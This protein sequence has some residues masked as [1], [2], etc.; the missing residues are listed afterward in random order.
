MERNGWES[1]GLEG[2]GS[3]LTRVVKERIGGDWTGLEVIGW[4]GMG[5]ERM[6]SEGK[7]WDRKGKVALQPQN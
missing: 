1:N 4:E 2:K 7:G 5:M 6:G 3:S